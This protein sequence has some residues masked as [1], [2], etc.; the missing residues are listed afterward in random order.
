ME[1]QKKKKFK[2]FDLYRDGKGVEKE[3][4]GPPNLKNFFKLFGR[5]FTRLL[6][7]NL[8]MLLEFLPLVFILYFFFTGEKTPSTTSPLYPALW[9]ASQVV[10]SPVF[11]PLFAQHGIQFQLPFVSP[12]FVLLIAAIAIIWL[13]T[14]GY[15]NVGTTYV[16]RSMV[17]SEPVFMWSDFWYAIRRNKKQ[18]LLVG[19]LDLIVLALLVFDL[20][21]FYNL[22]GSFWYDVMFYMIIAL[23][24]IYTFM[25]FYL[26][27]MLITFDLP[28]RKLIKNAFI[29][30]IVGIK[31]NFMAL[32]GA[33]A[34][35]AINYILIVMLAPLGIIVVV[36]LP[37]V[38][39][40]AC[41]SFMA[42]YAAWAKI[43]EL[44]I[45]P[46][47]NGEDEDNDGEG[48]YGDDGGGD[49]LPDPDAA[50]LL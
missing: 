11:A 4:V 23:I 26:Y 45:K 16:L 25:R 10:Q 3:E 48:G 47:K 21:Y 20:V 50:A 34:L 32:L 31:R 28:I 37:I 14:F 27:L 33:L 6:S 1:P 2:L 22:I 19:I 40:P 46:Y 17:R 29:F 41:A 43:D 30:A 7:L 13:L 42:A 49:M 36:I 18:G 8:Y 38:Y 35:A 39:Y 15:L 5:K 9:G 12:G 44:M 24:L